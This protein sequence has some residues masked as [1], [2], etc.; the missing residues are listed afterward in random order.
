MATNQKTVLIAKNLADV[1]YHTKTVNNLQILGGGTAVD[2]IKDKTVTLRH[3]SELTTIEKRERYIDFGSAVTLQQIINLGENKVPPFFYDALLSVGSRPLRNFATLGGNI[4]AGPIKH[5]LY[6]PLLALNARLEFKKEKDTLYLPFVNFKEI[7][8]KYVLTKIR[9]P[10][11]DWEVSVFKRV[12]P[13]RM[14]TSDSA[15]FVFLVDTQKNMIANIK[16]VF[17]GPVVFSFSSLENK[18]IGNKLPMNKKDI[19][20]IVTEAKILWETNFKAE[21]TNKILKEQFLNLLE[22]S[23][24]QLS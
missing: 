15:S 16:I 14:I 19:D 17:A 4:C 10:L 11:D 18:L 22:D 20:S 23:L 3:L 9:V 2:E 7:P 24:S 5:T 12:G 1:L 8:E 6:A 13:E 21:P